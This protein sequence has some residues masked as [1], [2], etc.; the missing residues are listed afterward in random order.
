M[1]VVVFQGTSLVVNIISSIVFGILQYQFIIFF[2]V[3]SVAHTPDFSSGW[4]LLLLI[5]LLLSFRI[6]KFNF[7]NFFCRRSFHK[8]CSCF[9]FKN[10]L[11][12]GEEGISL[13]TTG[14]TK[15]REVLSFTSFRVL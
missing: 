6:F 2:G 8:D 10:P 7:Y 3:G 11:R 4:D 14:K 15:G 5:F 12:E 9:S 13:R 1:G